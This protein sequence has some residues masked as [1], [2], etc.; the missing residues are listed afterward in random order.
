MSLSEEEFLGR[1]IDSTIGDIHRGFID[2]FAP[3]ACHLTGSH[4]KFRQPAL[5]PCLKFSDLPLFNRVS[6]AIRGIVLQSLSLFHP[7]AG[8]QLSLLTTSGHCTSRANAT[9]W[10]RVCSVVLPLEFAPA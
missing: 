10:S 4:A 9:N 3:F 6:F 8:T 7:P 5:E 2:Q 1:A